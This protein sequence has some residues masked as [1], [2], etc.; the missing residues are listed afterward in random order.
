MSNSEKKTIKEKIFIGCFLMF[1][2]VF[3]YMEAV[4]IEKIADKRASDPKQ[5][6]RGCLSYIKSR[7]D[8]VVDEVLIFKLDGKKVENSRLY[9][10]NSNAY[11]NRVKFEKYV[12]DNP[13][14]C[15]P[16]GYVKVNL[17]L[18]SKIY[19]YEYYGNSS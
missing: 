14:I 11:A 18:T 16:V 15:H 4:G 3:M 2:S 9:A 8:R 5:V 10:R 13:N 7:K 6:I 17:I 19:I 12:K 1:F